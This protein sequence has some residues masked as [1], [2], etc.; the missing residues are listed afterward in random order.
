MGDPRVRCTAPTK[1]SLCT[2]KNHSHHA[3][4]CYSSVG[5][6]NESLIVAAGNGDD[7]EG[8][9]QVQLIESSANDGSF[10][11]GE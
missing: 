8:V 3:I 5:V 11:M 7:E 10:G 9:S 1:I 4:R 2:S 6:P